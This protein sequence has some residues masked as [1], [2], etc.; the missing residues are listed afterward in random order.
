MPIAN[1]ARSMATPRTNMCFDDSLRARPRTDR[2]ARWSASYQASSH[3]MGGR[4]GGRS[5]TRSR[6]PTT[7]R[8]SS[9]WRK[10]AQTA[11]GHPVTVPLAAMST[12]ALGSRALSAQY[13][14]HAGTRASSHRLGPLPMRLRGMSRTGAT[15]NNPREDDTPEGLAQ[16]NSS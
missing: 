10:H 15:N 7:V 4:Q 13:W 9:T 2:R 16:R 5:R 14:P 11:A 6:R 8:Q 1:I 3:G 12:M